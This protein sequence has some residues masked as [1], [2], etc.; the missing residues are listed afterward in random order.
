MTQSLSNFA[1]ALSLAMIQMNSVRWTLLIALAIFL[2][3]LPL[4][5][6]TAFTYARLALLLLATFIMLVPFAW[7]ICAAFKDV[8]VLNEFMFLPP[9]HEISSKTVNFGNFHEL[10]TDRE[11][12]QG[13]V[14]F[15]QYLLNSIFLSSSITFLAMLFSSMGGYALAKYRFRGRGAVQVFMLSSLA[16]PGIV[17]LSPNYA[18]I[19]KLGMMDNYAALIVPAC[20][21]V[22]GIFLFRQA[23]IGVPD[24]LI[25]AARLD[26]CGEFRIYLSLVMPLVRPMTGAFCLISFLGAWNAFIAPNIYLQ[27]QR[28]LP[29]PVMLNQ[30]VG[31]YSQHYG[32]FLAGTLIAI[33]PPAILFFLLQREFISGLS[34]GAL[35]Q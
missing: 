33:L 35:K 7:L 3:L 6:K 5:R 21:S 14:S 13:P 11:T 15:W 28:L 23:M 10:F 30:Y 34:S 1:P 22:L 8:T 25:E 27:T 31:V 2:L 24:E 4:S 9:L 12:A 29:L 19:Y 32:V 26:G 20:V 16:I 18:V 17:L